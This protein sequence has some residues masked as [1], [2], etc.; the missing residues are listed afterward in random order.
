MWQ[1]WINTILGLWIILSPFTGM[2]ISTLTTNLVVVGIAVT[3]LG[4][5]EAFDVNRSETQHLHA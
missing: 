3:A 5:W 2:D 4:L 1:H